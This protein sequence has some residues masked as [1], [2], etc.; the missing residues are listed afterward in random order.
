MSLDF[1]GAEDINELH[2]D[3]K[4]KCD[5][6]LAVSVSSLFSEELGFDATKTQTLKQV[7]GNPAWMSDEDGGTQ[8]S[9]GL[10]FNEY[11]IVETGS[12]VMNL[13]PNVDG[14]ISPG[15]YNCLLNCTHAQTT[16]VLPFILYVRNS[17]YSG[18]LSASQTI[19]G[20]F[21]GGYKV[22]KR[23]LNGTT[24]GSWTLVS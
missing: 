21:A 18:F 24:W 5:A 8:A 20:D 23:S 4:T 10:E 6:A 7:K 11:E 1:K 3:L 17:T 19:T 2:N 16:Y 22:F 9:S 14:M 15:A 12:G 13:I